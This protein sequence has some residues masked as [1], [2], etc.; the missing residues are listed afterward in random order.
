MPLGLNRLAPLLAF[1]TLS[2][3]PPPPPPVRDLRQVLLPYAQGDLLEQLHRT[4]EVISTEYVEKGVLVRARV[5]DSVAGRVQAYSTQPMA[6]RPAR[7]S[8]KKGW[9]EEG[10]LDSESSGSEGGDQQWEDRVATP[11][12]SQYV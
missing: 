7:P 8:R 6:D 2:P 11:A 3:C 12:D 4:G 10:A 9:D 5:P 1:A